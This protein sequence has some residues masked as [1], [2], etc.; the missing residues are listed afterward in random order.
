MGILNMKRLEEHWSTDL[1]VS[2]LQFGFFTRSDSFTAESCSLLR[3]TSSSLRW[4]GLDFRAEAREAQLISDKLQ[5]NNLNKKQMI[6]RKIHLHKNH[7]NVEK[8]I[9][10]CVSMKWRWHIYSVYLCINQVNYKIKSLRVSEWI[11]QRSF[12]LVIWSF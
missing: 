12:F 4:E 8:K 6:E 11:I 10:Y 9:C 1:R 3:L 7:K 2:S 5:R